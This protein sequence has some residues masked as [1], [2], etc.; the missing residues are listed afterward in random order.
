MSQIDPEQGIVHIQKYVK[1][2]SFLGRG[3][4]RTGPAAAYET[5]L[6]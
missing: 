5:G 2:L 4:D 1:I 3:A 6:V